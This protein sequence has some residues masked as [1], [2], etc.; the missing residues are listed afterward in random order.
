MPNL[1]EIVDVVVPVYRGLAETRACLQAV[2][3][4]AG[5]VR[6]HLVVVSDH[7]PDEAL[8]AL[9]HAMAAAGQ[10]TLLENET[11]LGF[12]ATANR[13]MA[14]GPDRDVVL[15]NSDALVFDGWLDRL[16]AAANASPDIGTATPFSNN[17]TISSYPAFN[18]DNPLPG[19]LAPA[20]LDRL[21][22]AV[23]AGKRIDLPTAVGFCM[24]IRRDCLDDAGDFDVAAFGRG[25]G[26]E[27]DFCRRSAYLG[28]RHVLA[29][30]VFVVHAGG[31]SFGATKDAALACN[32]AVLAKRHPGYLPL[33]R[34]FL[35][36]DPVLPL[37]RAVDMARLAGQARGP[38]LVRLCHGKDGGTARRLSDEAAELAAAGYATALLAPAAPDEPD[39]RVRLTLDGA[40]G[41]PNLVYA[42]PE[43]LPALVA[44]LK[45]LGTAGCIFH[46][47]LDLPEAI[48]N[49]P[50]ALG[51][52][53]EAR[54][55]DYAWFCPRITL[56]DDTGLPCSEPDPAA[57]QRC[58]DVGEPLE[59]ADVPVAQLLARSARLLDA[60][61]RVIAPSGDAVG[62]MARHF[63]NAPIAALSHPEPA[64]APPPVPAFLPWDGTT[65]L[66]LALIGAIGRHKGYDVLLSMARDAARRELPLS[67]AVA[68]FTQ[69][70]YALFATGRVFVTGRYAEGEAVCVVR[71][72]GCQAALCL[73]VWP[74]T[75]CY[76]LTEAWRAGLWTVGF[77]L[78]A[79]G[80]RIAAAGYGWRLPLTLDGRAVNN[81]LLNLF[82]HPPAPGSVA[83]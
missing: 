75:W 28:W 71:E 43:E 40:A 59:T 30:D 27:N 66:R 63:P 15:L 12:P 68:G 56:V 45:A 61:G 83:S 35:R 21:F 26:E 29:A 42:L 6:P 23:N 44:D 55:H 60:A 34:D 17:A 46:H 73:S 31:V 38:L 4:A 13:G 16:A 39:N 70:D 79:V 80:E 78:G 74:E 65:P 81:R 72:L 9:M 69:D 82:A 67:F 22:A 64:F 24:Y 47:F 54:I 51:L 20:A 49:L 3:A 41:T 10:I 77:D 76:T 11:N 2:L 36:R 52:P 1:P 53:Y 19:D 18:I 14:Q 62:R 25:Y 8:T 57:C 32:L 37:R 48:L 5:T 50:A 58:I 33:V 7:C